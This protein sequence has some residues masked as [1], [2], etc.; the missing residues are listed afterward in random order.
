MGISCFF[1]GS[2]PGAP[3]QGLLRLAGRVFPV[4]LGR[5]GLGADKREGDGR[6]PTGVWR[7]T[8]ALYRSDRGPRPGGRLPFRPIGGDDGWCDDPLDRRYNRPVRLP[9]AARHET[10]QREDGLYDLVLV[11]DYNQRPRMK[12][13]GSAV[14]IHA[15]GPGLAPTAGCVA[16][17]IAELRRL[18]ARLTPGARMVVG[19]H[20]GRK[21]RVGR[22]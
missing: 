10:L 13:R 4:A 18:V 7:V 2:R 17:P 22:A 21:R 14:F 11:L 19:T 6:T 8:R 1:V 9:C 12:G 20:H 5:R 3:H 16:M 15:A